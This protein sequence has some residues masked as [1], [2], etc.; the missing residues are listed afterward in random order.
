VPIEA[1]MRQVFNTSV[2]T[3]EVVVD[4]ESDTVSIYRFDAEHRPIAAAME[5]W[6]YVDLVDVLN[7]HAGVPLYEANTIAA[8]LRALHSSGPSFAERVAETRRDR[9]WGSLENAGI[10]L[11]FVALLLDSVLVLIPMILAIAYL[12]GGTWENDVHDFSGRGLLFLALCS[13]GYFVVT[14]AATGAT[15]GKLMVG[16]RVVGENGEPITF[17]A[18]FVRNLLRS[19]DQLF[20][21]FVGFIFA[22]LSTRGQRLGDRAAHTIVVRR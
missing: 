18:A 20:F 4:R 19:V 10:P 16:I 1:S 17:G 22:I 8:E 15:L 5:S 13:F 3:V 11:R 12:D 14:E 6:A 7:R 2:G 9:A 21:Y